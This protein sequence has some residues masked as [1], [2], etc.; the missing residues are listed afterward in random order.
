VKSNE[1][2]PEVFCSRLDRG[3]TS[4]TGM[5]RGTQDSIAQPS[6]ACG[7]VAM[8]SY[9]FQQISAGCAA[10]TPAKLLSGREAALEAFSFYKNCPCWRSGNFRLADFQFVISR[11]SISLPCGFDANRI[12]RTFLHSPR[13]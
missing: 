11:I 8:V 9:L 2:V 4:H 12:P 7:A 13:S 10:I 6:F 1:V 3:V 5:L